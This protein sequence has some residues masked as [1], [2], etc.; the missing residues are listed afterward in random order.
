MWAWLVV[1]CVGGAAVGVR[2]EAPTFVGASPVVVGVNGSVV[3]AQVQLDGSATLYWLVVPTAQAASPLSWEVLV[4]GGGHTAAL[5]GAMEVHG[6]GPHNLSLWGDGE[7]TRGMPWQPLVPPSMRRAQMGGGLFYGLDPYDNATPL[8]A[9][10]PLLQLDSDYSIFLLAER[11][12]AQGLL[13]SPVSP[14]LHV[15]TAAAVGCDPPPPLRALLLSDC[16][17]CSEC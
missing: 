12:T 16:A 3:S 8:C 9:R 5:C 6:A 10:C 1:L 7:C 13:R 15:R 2:A 17:Q 11:R 4:A 14:T